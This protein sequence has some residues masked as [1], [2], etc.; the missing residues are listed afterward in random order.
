METSIQWTREHER[1]IYLVT[2]TADGDSVACEI[3][4]LRRKVE[5]YWGYH[6][7]VVSQHVTELLTHHK[8]QSP[9]VGIA[10]MLK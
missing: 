8:Q 7:D 4:D 6:W 5:S 2:W 9:C 3:M 1:L 10:V